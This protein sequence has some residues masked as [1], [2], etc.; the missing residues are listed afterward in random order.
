VNNK[1]H[2]LYYVTSPFKYAYFCATFA[3]PMCDV[4]RYMCLHKAN[5]FM[6]SGHVYKDGFWA[7]ASARM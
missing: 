4:R 5:L 1:F 6:D 2:I 3:V 7:E